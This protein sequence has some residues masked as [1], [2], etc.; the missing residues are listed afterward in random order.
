M[1]ETLPNPDQALLGR[2]Q[3]IVQNLI[4]F[5]NQRPLDQHV[6]LTEANPHLKRVDLGMGCFWGAERLFWQ[7]Q[8]V[9]V[10]AVGY[11]GGYT[12]NPTYEEVCSGMT[13][14]VELVRVIFDSTILS[15]SGILKIFFEK[16]DPTQGNRQGNDLG[17][18]YRSAIYV[19][20]ETDLQVAQSIAAS[21]SHLLQQNQM[22]PLTTEIALS[23]NFYL[24]EA[25]HQQ[26]L[27]KN[28][29]GY[30]GIKGTGLVCII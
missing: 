11:G 16:H 2:D 7:T 10:T 21:F 25:M 4:H 17:T 9:Y 12:P 14:H 29:E 24:A 28:P 18:Q 1:R 6:P 30:C 3:P 19:E 26:Y 13:A 22:P 20:S 8:G 23:R 5:V 27:A 15:L